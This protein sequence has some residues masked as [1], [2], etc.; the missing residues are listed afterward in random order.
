MPDEIIIPE[1]LDREPVS[2]KFLPTVRYFTLAIAALTVFYSLYFII[3]IIP[4]IVNSAIIFK[5]LS[6]FML[7]FSASTLYKHLTGLNIVTIT[8]DAL[9]LRFILKKR[10]TIPWS[11]L[12]RME[13][14]RAIT[15]YWKIVY[16]DNTGVEK[17][18]KT[19]LSFPGVVQILFNVLEHKP[20]LEMNDLLSKVLQFKKRAQE[21]TPEA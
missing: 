10:I 19:S 20:D 16:I 5:I 11:N 6:I 2:Y 8:N 13:I 15:H 17:T 14:Y 18:Y 21:S 1:P 12:K 7:Y 3:M 9:I 4:R